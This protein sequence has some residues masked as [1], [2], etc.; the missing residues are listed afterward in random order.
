LSNDD[1]TDNDSDEDTSDPD[2]RVLSAEE[3]D[4]ALQL[5]D[6]VMARI[7]APDLATN[8]DGDLD[9]LDTLEETPYTFDESDPVYSSAEGFIEY[10]SYIN[11]IRNQI[12]G[13]LSNA[14]F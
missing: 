8:R 11:I 12:V 4:N 6:T 2:L 10:F 14:R 3:H 1:L 9:V 13:K 5:L 7:D